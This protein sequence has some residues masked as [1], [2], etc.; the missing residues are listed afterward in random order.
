MRLVVLLISIFLIFVSLGIIIG[1]ISGK[2]LNRNEK[3][4]DPLAGIPE[5]QE[6]DQYFGK[7]SY[8]DPHFFPEDDISFA[9][10]DK[11]NKEVILLKSSNGDNSKLEVVE[12]FDVILFGEVTTTKDKSRE[13]LVVEK[14]LIRKGRQ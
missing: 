7:I 10:Y 9:L 13:V 5:M 12:G 8:K 14:V 3:G 1:N 6:S 4:N 2:L 11:D